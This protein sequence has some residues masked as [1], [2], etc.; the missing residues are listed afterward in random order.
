MR[1]A[2]RQPQLVQSFSSPA[3]D[4]QERLHD[5]AQGLSLCQT[6][7]DQQAQAPQRLCLSRS[8]SGRWVIFQIEVK[9]PVKLLMK[10]RVML[11]GAQ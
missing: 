3:H 8:T 1:Q 5:L 11:G 9:D 4:A 7:T 6:G 10:S 2:R